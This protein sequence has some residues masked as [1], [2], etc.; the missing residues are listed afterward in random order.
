VSSR[1]CEALRRRSLSD[2]SAR[3]DYGGAAWTA[4]DIRGPTPE[5]RKRLHDTADVEQDDHDAW[6]GTDAALSAGASGSTVR[7]RDRGD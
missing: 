1:V 5:R 7:P 6:R 3:C 2:R 4:W